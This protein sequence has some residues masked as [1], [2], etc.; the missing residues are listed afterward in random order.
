MLGIDL[1]MQEHESRL[2][3]V[4]LCAGSGALENWTGRFD[5]DGR[6]AGSGRCT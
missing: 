3:A 2:M 5:D 6:K 1:V 4:T